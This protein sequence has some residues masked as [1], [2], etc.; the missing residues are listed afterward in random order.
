VSMEKNAGGPALKMGDLPGRKES[1]F[2]GSGERGNR[3]IFYLLQ[4]GRGSKTGLLCRLGKEN[5]GLGRI[6]AK[7]TF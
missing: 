7:R 5:T 3:K 1:S 6:P 2:T 4:G